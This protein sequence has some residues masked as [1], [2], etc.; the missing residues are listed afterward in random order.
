MADNKS[1]SL[2]KPERAARIAKNYANTPRI[3]LT[4]SDWK[5]L[6][7]EGLLNE[8]GKAAMKL[9]RASLKKAKKSKPSMDSVSP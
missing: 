7:S 8:R 3:G 5:R 6:S 4:L 1:K 9:F 2:L